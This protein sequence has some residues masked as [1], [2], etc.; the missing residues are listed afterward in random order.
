MGTNHLGHFL[1][2]LLLLP[3]LRSTAKQVRL[4][5]SCMEK[6]WV[7]IAEK[8]GLPALLVPSSWAWGH[9]HCS[10]TVFPRICQ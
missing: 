4:G 7:C 2:T 8:T 9:V 6:A 5:W 10:G 1:L 3:S